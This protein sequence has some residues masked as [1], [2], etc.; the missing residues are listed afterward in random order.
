[1]NISARDSSINTLT[2]LDRSVNTLA[3]ESRT[4][5]L[6]QSERLEHDAEVAR[7]M[8]GI[9]AQMFVK[10]LRRGLGDGFFGTGPGADTFEGWLD[11]NLGKSLAREGVLDLAGRIKTSLAAGRQHQADSQAAQQAPGQEVQR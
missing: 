11:E 3:L 5:K 6:E 10:E 2:A 4:A 1:M 7:D 8:E 9:F